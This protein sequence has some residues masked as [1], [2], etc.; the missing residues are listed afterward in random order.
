MSFMYCWLH[1]PG[2]LLESGV[3]AG[4]TEVQFIAD[5]ALSRYQPVK[6]PCFMSAVGTAVPGMAVLTSG[7]V[8]LRCSSEKKKK[9][10]LQL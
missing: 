5:D 2:T 10:V 8:Y 7:I 9:V 3:P 6:N 4:N 1:T